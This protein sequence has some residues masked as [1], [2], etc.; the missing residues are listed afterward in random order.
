MIHQKGGF[1]LRGTDKIF[2]LYCNISQYFSFLN[3]TL[4]V[5]SNIEKQPEFTLNNCHNIPDDLVFLSFKSHILSN[6]GAVI[7]VAVESMETFSY[8][9]KVLCSKT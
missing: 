6:A 7:Y 1:G 4:E 8:S 2:S 9:S 5:L 3:K